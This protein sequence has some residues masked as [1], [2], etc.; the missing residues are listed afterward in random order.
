MLTDEDVHEAVEGAKATGFRV[1]AD[2]VVRF[3]D[4]VLRLRSYLRAIVRPSAADE[5]VF[6]VD[7]QAVA[8]A[9]QVWDE[10]DQK[11]NP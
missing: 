9:I 3:G 11:V 6:A 2:R 1:Y 7:D 10:E 4:E 8:D 5:W